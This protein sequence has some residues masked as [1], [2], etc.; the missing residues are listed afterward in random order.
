M[1]ERKPNPGRY[2]LTEDQV[3]A[4]RLLA[5][6]GG[7]HWRSLAAQH[8]RE[9][10]GYQ[11]DP[12]VPPKKPFSRLCRE[13]YGDD[14][15]YLE[16]DAIAQ[17]LWGNDYRGLV[18]PPATPERLREAAGA[19]EAA[20]AGLQ[21]CPPGHPGHHEA[22]RLKTLAAARF[23]SLFEPEGWYHHNNFLYRYRRVATCGWA[24]DKVDLMAGVVHI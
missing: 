22:V 5:Y 17:K 8:A 19:Y 1:A 4:L 13:R 9:V 3:L 14:P 7:S 6:H 20:F 15:L 12:T 16:L 18:F 21:L 10:L 23:F 24:V 11:W 2:G